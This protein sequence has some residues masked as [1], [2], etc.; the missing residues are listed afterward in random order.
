MSKTATMKRTMP[1]KD[2]EPS[3]EIREYLEALSAE[4]LRGLSSYVRKM[5][6]GKENPSRAPGSE[7]GRWLEAQ[8]KNGSGPYFYLRIYEVGKS[9]RVDRAGHMR[10]GRDK[11]KYVGR[12]LPADLA[13]EF[14][15]PE[16]VTPEES[17]IH[18]TGAPRS[19]KR[20]IGERREKS[21]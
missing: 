12:R 3:A 2:F 17:G 9:T 15:Y 6:V 4:E 20:N 7:G 21:E 11:S 14:G 5:A 18:I 1:E 16:G 19:G 8:Y 13:E 10:S